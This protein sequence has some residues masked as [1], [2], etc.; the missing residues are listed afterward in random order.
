MLI[1]LVLNTYWL[2]N[3]YSKKE[4]LVRREN[5]ARNFV[6]KT[7]DGNI[8]STSARKDES[9]VGKLAYKFW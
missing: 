7:P 9:F 4:A 5:S 2:R 6:S 3:M 8:I 1:R